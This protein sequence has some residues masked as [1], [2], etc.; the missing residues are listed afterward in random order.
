MP[1]RRIL[2]LAANFNTY[3]HWWGR[4]SRCWFVPQSSPWAG[5]CIWGPTGLS[6]SCT[7]ARLASGIRTWAL[8]TWRG[9][10]DRCTSHW[11]CH[12][13]GWCGWRSRPRGRPP[14]HWGPRR[15]AAAQPASGPGLR[16]ETPGPSC[17]ARSAVS[18]A[19][20]C[21]WAGMSCLC[22]RL[23]SGPGTW[24][25]VVAG[26][27][28]VWM[29]LVNYLLLKSKGCVNSQCRVFV[30]DCLVIYLNWATDSAV[31]CM[32]K[33]EGRQNLVNNTHLHRNTY[34]LSGLTQCHNVSVTIRI[35]GCNY[36]V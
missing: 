4:C 14:S 6:A 28:F 22:W 33:G 21:A 1:Y 10:F 8:R 24:S 30:M 18:R 17:A 7:Y 34:F 3:R 26:G 32:I 25:H 29:L 23:V 5:S 35:Q 20:T 19:R 16:S 31:L 15:E 9:R 13:W 11:W 27:R 36:H 12:R 2:T